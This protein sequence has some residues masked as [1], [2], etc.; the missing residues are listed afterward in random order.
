[1]HLAIFAFV[2]WYCFHRWPY[3]TWKVLGVFVGLIIL[4]LAVGGRQQPPVVIVKSEARAEEPEQRP[5]TPIR[6]LPRQT[7]GRTY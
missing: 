5:I 1:M 3:G 6:P 7:S 4:L 2:V